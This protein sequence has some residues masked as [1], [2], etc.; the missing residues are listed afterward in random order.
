MKK[1]EGLFILNTAG[2]E[3]TIQELVDRIAKSI[4]DEG[5]TVENIQKMD[6]KQFVRVADKKYAS[7][8]YANIVFS[9]EEEVINRMQTKYQLDEDV[10]RVIFTVAKATPAPAA[11]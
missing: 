1:Y 11:A 5:C 4:S 3:D 6:K 2:K 10:F 7:G 8:Y 9:A